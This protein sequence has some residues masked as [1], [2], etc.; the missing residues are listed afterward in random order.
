MSF[1]I[2]MYSNINLNAYQYD[3]SWL[4]YSPTGITLKVSSTIGQ[5][6][7]IL[8]TY[9]KKWNNCPKINVTGTSD[10][11]NIYHYGE[12]NY[13]TGSYAEA[14]M[15]NRSHK[16]ITYY[17]SFTSLNDLRKKETIV[18][19]VGHCFG[20]DHCQSNKNSIAVMRATG[21]NDKAYPLSD[22]K[23]GINAIY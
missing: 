19:E 9:T 22:D 2:L 15:T 1:V 16:S 14:S 18:H 10:S 21:F 8:I 17:Q 11:Y 3:S 23:A 13:Y 4:F 20:L 5:H 7:S 12:L 6:S